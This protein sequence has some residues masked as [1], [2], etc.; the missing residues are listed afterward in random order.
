M[1]VPRTKEEEEALRTSC[2]N[3][4]DLGKYRDT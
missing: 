2:V 4:F 3:R 1:T